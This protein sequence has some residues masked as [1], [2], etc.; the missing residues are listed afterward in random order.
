MSERLIT[1]AAA[2]AVSLEAARR[3]AR[4]DVDA[5]GTSELDDDIARSVRAFTREAEHDTG[6]AFVFQTW[7]LTLDRFSAALKSPRAP[8][9]SVAHVKFYDVDGVQQTL[10]PRDYLIDAESEPG[11]LVPAPGRAWPATANRIS[12]VEIEFVCGY[13]PD[14]AL[15]PDE[16][17]EYILA[18]V[19]QKFAPVAT[20]K[21]ANFESLLDGIKVYG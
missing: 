20:A 6:R 15:V 14:D 13:G 9:A 16:A 21:V 7:R 10:D 12:A 2:L 3:A 11:Y 4:V 1:P 8:L 17:K 5:D 19:N 18:R